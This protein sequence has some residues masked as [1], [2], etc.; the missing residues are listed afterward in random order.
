[1]R[2][3]CP[4]HESARIFFMF[5]LIGRSLPGEARRMREAAAGRVLHH[6]P[7]RPGRH[8]PPLRRVEAHLRHHRGRAATPTA[9]STM[10][11]SP[12][13]P[14]LHFESG[15]RPGAATGAGLPRAAV[16]DGTSQDAEADAVAGGAWA[17]VDHLDHVIAA[18]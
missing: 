12:I 1:M 4:F 16:A 7:V 10:M 11:A 17:A 14:V 18:P 8:R 13:G 9:A 3:H 15:Y 6:A 2:S 5:Q